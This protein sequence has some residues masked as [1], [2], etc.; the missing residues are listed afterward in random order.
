[1]DAVSLRDLYDHHAWAV[2]RVLARA[3]EV[4]PERA[5]EVSRPGMLSLRDTLAHIVSAEGYWLAR[6]QVRERYVRFRPDSVAS[7]AAGWMPLQAEVR[8]YLAGLEPVDLNRQLARY[9]HPRDRRTLGAAITHVLLHGAQ[10]TAEAAELL[11][12][13]GH[14]PGQL[15]YMEFL[16]LREHALPLLPTKREG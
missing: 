8:A 10:H 6:W 5:A 13:L 9:P 2:D 14:S 3:L 11:T 12:Q 1:M 15:D 16:D 7:V 4:S